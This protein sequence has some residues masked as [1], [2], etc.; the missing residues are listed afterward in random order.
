MIQLGNN[1]TISY[2]TEEIPCMVIDEIKG[3]EE[4]P[5]PPDNPMLLLRELN[6]IRQFVRRKK[7]CEQF[8]LTGECPK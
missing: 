8:L 5:H 3:S 7:A 1:V 4:R 2:G 6:G